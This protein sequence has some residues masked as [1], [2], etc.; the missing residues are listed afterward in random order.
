MSRPSSTQMAIINAIP[1]LGP[2]DLEAYSSMASSNFLFPQTSGKQILPH[3]LPEECNVDQRLPDDF[4]GVP[5]YSYVIRF[6]MVRDDDPYGQ[7]I[8]AGT[9]GYWTHDGDGC[10]IDSQDQIH[11]IRWVG[12]GSSLAITSDQD[13]TAELLLFGSNCGW[14]TNWDPFYN[15]YVNAILNTVWSSWK[16]N[17]A[18]ANS[19]QKPTTMLIDTCGEWRTDGT[20]NSPLL[21]SFSSWVLSNVM[22]PTVIEKIWMQS[23]NG[24]I[25]PTFDD[26]LLVDGNSRRALKI[27]ARRIL[28]EYPELLEA[29]ITLPPSDDGM[30]LETTINRRLK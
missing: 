17:G 13:W 28:T 4:G 30:P 6:T 24:S 16:N 15:G 18:V 9:V 7:G 26:E 14:P 8:P 20:V 11:G 29:T 27:T 2:Y 22:W 23:I 5:A 19:P 21:G 12:Q 25:K 3:N 1:E 10:H